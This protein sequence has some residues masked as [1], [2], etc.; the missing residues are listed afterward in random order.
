MLTIDLNCDMGEGLSNDIAIMPYISSANIACG[1][2]A[3]DEETMRLTVESAIQYN[4]AIGAHPGFHDKENFGRKEMNLTD[5]QIFDL[6]FQQLSIISAIVNK[7]Q[8]KLNHVKPHGALYN[9]AGR[10][11]EIADQICNAVK[12]FDPGL[13]IYGLSGGELIKSATKYSLKAVNEVF[14]D[15]TYEDDGSLTPRTKPAAVINDVSG[16]IDQ[17]LQMVQ[18]GSVISTSGKKIPV[19]AETICI[20]GDGPHA[21]EF[22]KAI[23]DTLVNQKIKIQPF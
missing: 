15:R 2:H 19:V 12:L 23:H 3:G 16:A 22:A 4:V 6:M 8:A 1:F 17:V 5:R 9:M 14:S 10:N 11:T 20:H 7:Y 21:L 18:A 13:A